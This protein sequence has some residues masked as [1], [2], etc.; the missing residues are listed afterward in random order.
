[1]G[2]M[3]HERPNCRNP[4]RPKKGSSI[5]VGQQRSLMSAERRRCVISR[6]EVL[7]EI[8]RWSKHIAN[9]SDIHQENPLRFR[10]QIEEGDTGAPSETGG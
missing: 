3:G 1:M 2:D 6:H 9:V 10:R 5:Q 8:L 7:T 4:A